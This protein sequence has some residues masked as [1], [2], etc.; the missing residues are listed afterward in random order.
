[1]QTRGWWHWADFLVRQ[2]ALQGKSP[3]FVSIDE[4]SV[5]Q[6][7][8]LRKGVVCGKKWWRDG[9]QPRQ[10]VPSTK[11]RGAITFL[12][13]VTHVPA[14]QAALPH[15][16]LGNKRLLPDKVV[17]A[18]GPAL[19]PRLVV[20]NA[21]SGWMTQGMMLKYMERLCDALAAFPTFQ[22]IICFDCASSHL[23]AE[24]LRFMEQ[25]QVY[26]L[27]VPASTTSMLQP[28][29]LGL[30]WPLKAYLMRKQR[31]A[32]SVG[33]E[34]STQSLLLALSDAVRDIICSRRWLWTFESCGLLGCRSQLRGLLAQVA[35]MY[36]EVSPDVTTPPAAEVVMSL[37]PKG[38]RLPY[39]L[40]VSA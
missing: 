19:S 33:G 11:R 22:P 30:F 24:L 25:Q 17:A 29:D 8:L 4:S 36:A 16:V 28:A 23:S 2:A 20:H 18:V 35:E 12:G 37:L 5:S 32:L 10:L 27:Y 40:L 39:E 7:F 3:L 6:W 21:K 26:P 1:M 9:A 13:A 15:L 34:F 38:R 14:V 31:A